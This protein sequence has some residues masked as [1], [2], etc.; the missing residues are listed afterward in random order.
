MEQINEY[1][2]VDQSKICIN[3]KPCS[4]SHK[5]YSKQIARFFKNVK[6]MTD[7]KME[8]SRPLRIESNFTHYIRH[9]WS[10]FNV[11]QLPKPKRTYEMSSPPIKLSSEYPL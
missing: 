11:R 9:H 10:K 4:L 7:I 1:E 2:R 6:E 3:R 8:Q 5:E